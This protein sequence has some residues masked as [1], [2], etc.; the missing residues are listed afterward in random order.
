M[1]R[2][3]SSAGQARDRDDGITGPANLERV[4]GIEPSS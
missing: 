4:K 1:L 2:R 3:Q